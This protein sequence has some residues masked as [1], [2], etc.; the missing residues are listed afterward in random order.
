VSGAFAPLSGVRVL[1]LTYYASGPIAAMALADLGAD[2]IKVEPPGGE[3]GR[4]LGVTFPGGWST[5]FLSMN[6]N[7]RSLCVDYRKPEGAELLRDLAAQVD[8]L[9]Q[10]SRPGAWKRYALDYES[11]TELNPRLI[12]GSVSGFGESGPMSG[13]LAMDPIAQASGGIMAITGS[14]E[15][16]PVKVGA[17][18]ADVQAGRNLAFGVLAALMQRGRTGQGCEVTTSLFDT[19]VANLSMRE[20]EFQFTGRNPELYGTAHGQIVPGQAFRTKDDQLVVFTAYTD[21]HFRR[22]CE[23]VNR[24]DLADDPRFASNADRAAHA[25]ECVE[26]VQKVMAEFTSDEVTALLAG[27]LPFGPVLRFSELFSHPQLAV[28][29]TMVEFEQPG[30]GPIRAIGAPVHFDA[31]PIEV[32]Y[33]CPELGEHTAELLE[34][35]GVPQE[36]FQ[37]LSRKGIVQVQQLSNV[38]RTAEYQ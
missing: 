18:I 7:K 31:A 37:E 38:Q 30:V 10:N 33:P 2:V 32:R 34:Q 19:V 1:D 29:K 13:W 24:P 14:P 3:A 20:V 4:R 11:L 35:F 26:A 25:S 23:L 27:N 15:S 22:W 5:F 12:Y 16:G 17:A 28:N 9:I 36:R 8:V 21:E 6:R